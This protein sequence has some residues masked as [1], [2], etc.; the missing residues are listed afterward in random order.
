[1]SKPLVGKLAKDLMSQDY[2]IVEPTE[3]VLSVV[4]KLNEKNRGGCVVMDAI[5]EVVGM[6]TERD[7]LRRV[8]GK[9][10]DPATTS[11]NDVMTKDV[12]FA[13]A[14]DDAWELLRVMLQA[15]FRTLPVAEGRKLVGLITLK[16]FSRALMQDPSLQG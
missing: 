14:N 4:N 5:K 6:F 2:I 10:L 3:N 7:L 9:N 13:Q 1:M 8:V 12:I 11:V 15:N 16:E